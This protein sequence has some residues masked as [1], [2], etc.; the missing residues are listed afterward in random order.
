LPDG[1]LM[2]VTGAPGLAHQS[3]MAAR[4]RARL[5]IHCELS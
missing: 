5:F 1:G 3:E 4:P 2:C